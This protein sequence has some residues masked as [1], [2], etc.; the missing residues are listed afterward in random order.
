MAGGILSLY[1]RRCVQGGYPFGYETGKRNRWWNIIP[2][3]EA[4]APLPEKEQKILD[5]LSRD[6]EQ[7]VTQ[8]EKTAD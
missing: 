5:L 4:T 3:F 1:I 6:T 8:L 2:N 7:C